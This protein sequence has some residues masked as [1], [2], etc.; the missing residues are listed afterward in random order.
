MGLRSCRLVRVPM[1]TPVHSLKE[2]TM[3]WTME[4]WK[5][6][7]WF[8]ELHFILDQV[9]GQV[10]VR[11]I[12]SLK[13]VADHVQSWTLSWQCC[14]LMSVAIFSRIMYPATCQPVIQEW[15]EEHQSEWA[16]MG[17]AGQINQ[18]VLVPDTTEHVQ[19]FCGV[20]S[21]KISEQLWQHEG[22]RILSK[23]F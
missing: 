13:N 10:H 1:I 2:R 14:S 11:H 4:Q 21:S 20:Q 19:V 18:N 5:N 17:R 3:D 9:D 8:D 6:V 22:G 7:A 16:S 12:T 15:F 23:W